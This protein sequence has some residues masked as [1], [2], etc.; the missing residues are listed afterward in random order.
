MLDTAS[1]EGKDDLDPMDI[2]QF[3]IDAAKIVCITH[4][5][6]LGSS[7]G[8]AIF[9]KDMLFDLS[10]LIDWKQLSKNINSLLLI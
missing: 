7:Q 5:T 3:I 1:L 6:T 4:H 8:A 10:C 9:G 2:E